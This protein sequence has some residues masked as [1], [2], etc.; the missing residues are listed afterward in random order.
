MMRLKDLA[1]VNGDR[2]EYIRARGEYE[3]KPVRN[4]IAALFSYAASKGVE[5]E[6]I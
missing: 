1:S 6:L 5:C 2:T 4:F 3:K